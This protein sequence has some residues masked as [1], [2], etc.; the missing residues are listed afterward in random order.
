MNH[1]Y[2]FRCEL[3]SIASLRATIEAETR[4]VRDEE[5]L[6]KEEEERRERQKKLDAILRRTSGKVAVN[7]APTAKVKHHC[8]YFQLFLLIS[9]E[10][11]KFLTH[12]P[13]LYNSFLR[14][15]NLGIL[16]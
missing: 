9:S 15:H 5:R 13:S 1:E 7:P 10:N 8:F 12:H 4:R 16:N 11:L 14:C 6:A 2:M 3:L